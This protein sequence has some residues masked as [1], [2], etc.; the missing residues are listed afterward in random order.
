MKAIRM[1]E[2]GEAETLQIDDLPMPQ[3]EP[4]QVL[5]RTHAAGVNPVDW[6]IRGGHARFMFDP[7]LPLT[8][9]TE[10]SGT[11][12]AVGEGVEGLKAGDKVIVHTGLWDAYAE[13]FAVDA[14]NCVPVPANIDLDKAGNIAMSV[15]TAL[16]LVVEAAQPKAG[17][18][19]VIVGAAGAVG[20][21]AIQ[22]A[23]NMGVEVYGVG[24]SKNSEKIAALGA[25][26][27]A[28]DAPD[29]AQFPQA[30]IVIDLVGLEA[31]AG[32][33]DKLK[34]G[35]KYISSVGPMDLP[36]LIERGFDAS[37]FGL[38]VDGDRLRKTVEK[39]AE[40]VVTLD[41]PIIFSFAQAA[42]AHKLSETGH[43]PGRII[44]KP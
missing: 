33:V 30:D 11:I 6:K 26:P 2:Y 20:R 4:G 37:F 32:A 17:D 43:A 13:Y 38:G 23:R 39:V 18:V 1:H 10:A 31:A 9:G 40:G 25:R 19:L 42:E 27:I 24:S 41:D 7:P 28:Y 3:P 22:I 35:G 44:L 14:G 21:A 12:E 29:G 34:P 16:G 36:A 5:V 15:Q 8:L